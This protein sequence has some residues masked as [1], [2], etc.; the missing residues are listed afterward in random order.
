MTALRLRFPYW[1]KS[2]PLVL[3]LE[4]RALYVGHRDGRC[5]LGL[6]RT[7][8]RRIS[9]LTHM[10]CLVWLVLSRTNGKGPQSSLLHEKPGELPDH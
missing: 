8:F 10:V 6:P 1:D 9:E 5:A 2:F 3:V 7:C 4:L